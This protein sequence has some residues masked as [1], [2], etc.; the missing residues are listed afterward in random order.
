LAYDQ[1]QG[2][3]V[4]NLMAKCCFLEMIFDNYSDAVS[5]K[6]AGVN[7]ILICFDLGWIQILNR[8]KN[9]IIY[10]PIALVQ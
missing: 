3:F 2:L 5:I 4:H 6:N 1:T 8:V 10:W 9:R 7:A